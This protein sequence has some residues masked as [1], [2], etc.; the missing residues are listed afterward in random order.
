MKTTEKEGF[1]GLAAE[2]LSPLKRWAEFHK[3]LAGGRQVPIAQTPRELV[4]S[5]DTLSLYR[6]SQG[7]PPVLLV[8]SLVNRPAV[9][10]LVS[11]RSVVERYVEAGYSVYLLDW[12]RPDGLDQA[13][14]L[15]SYVSGLLRL[16][17]REVCRDSG[18][19]S[20]HLMG[21][22]MGGTLSAIYTAL[23]PSRVRS[24]TLLGTPLNFRSP[25]LLYKW[26]QGYDVAKIV[27]AWAMAPAWS[28]DGYS[29]LT[30][31]TK[32]AR[33][34]DLYGKLDDPEFM[35]S[36][37]AMEQWVSDNVSMAGACYAEF[38]RTHF[39]ENQL[40]EGRFVLGERRVDLSSIRC[41]VLVVAGAKD[42]LV[43]PETTGVSAFSNGTE[44]VFPAGH[45][46]LSVS[47]QAHQKL[48]PEVMK[49]LKKQ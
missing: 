10:D 6:Y 13:L 42:H 37:L 21:Y 26:A 5:R 45:I 29:L 46:G 25:Q 1:A 18:S 40:W 31:D 28:F 19:P 41:P 8:Y 2:P 35:H 30:L 32:P 49:W 3:V 48:W 43:P 27:D 9:L 14:D 34:R 22:C 16:V 17:V 36:Y 39:V 44:I 15:S 7:G 24:L 12:G 38:C 4:Y 33:L 11:G 47:R 23:Y 20:M